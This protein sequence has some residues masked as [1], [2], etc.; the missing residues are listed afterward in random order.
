[1]RRHG[2]GFHEKHKGQL[3]CDDSAEQI[4]DHAAGRVRCRCRAALAALQPGRGAGGRRRLRAGH[5]R[6]PVRCTQLVVA[7]G[8]LSI[9]KIGATDFGHRLA[10][11]FGHKPSW[12][13][14]RPWCR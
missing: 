2:I 12:R 10:R 11:Q 7:S 8:G 6:G 5:Q 1:V 3:F 4:I 9:P 14:A 13:H